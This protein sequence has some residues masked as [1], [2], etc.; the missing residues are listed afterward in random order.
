MNARALYTSQHPVIR[1]SL[2]QLVDTLIAACDDRRQDSV[3]LL[4][5]GEELVFDGRPLRGRGLHQQPVIRVLRRRG[6]ER[7]TLARGLPAE[8]AEQL[9][10]GLV[11]GDAL[12]STPHVILGHA[13]LP[14]GADAPVAG[15]G[16]ELTA[17]QV[18]TAMEQFLRFRKDGGAAAGGFEELVW[19]FIELLSQS[20]RGMLPVVPLKSHDEYT[21]VHSVNVSLLVLAQA[22]ALGLDGPLLHSVGMAALLHDVGKL[23][24]P[25]DVLHKPGKLEGAE[26]RI[27]MSHAELGAW[28]LCQLE[29][30]A[31]L[32]ILVAFEHHLRIDGQPNYPPLRVPRAPT[33]ASQLTALADVYDAVRT[34]R[35]YR[36]A[37]PQDAAL[38]ILRARAGTFHDPYLVGNFCRLVTTG[39]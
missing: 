4:R 34:V 29:R 18:T 11:T 15:G 21:F 9:V 26:W 20:T 36:G 1:Q 32:S 17:A 14:P 7:L 30:S 31:P 2:Q 3:T 10:A 27:M 33:L 12:R 8:E 22:R 13:T 6:I 35:P 25:L 23:A 16:A 37:L 5:L 38:D 39:A 19:T 24:I 28:Q